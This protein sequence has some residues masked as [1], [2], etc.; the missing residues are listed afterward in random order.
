MVKHLE[1]EG[2]SFSS[3]TTRSVY[4]E[5]GIV[6]K[7]KKNEEMNNLNYTTT[8]NPTSNPTTTNPTTTNPKTN[9]PT[10]N[11]PTTNNPTFNNPT[12]NN[13]PLQDKKTQNKVIDYAD[14]TI[15]DQDVDNISP[16]I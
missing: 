12:D 14:Y 15:D 6:I 1:E 10:T 2:L 4:K 7:V 5:K 11:N 13:L 16:L 9:N 8:D 3:S